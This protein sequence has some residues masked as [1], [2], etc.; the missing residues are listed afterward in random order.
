MTLEKQQ[1]FY[2]FSSVSV[3]HLD[4]TIK[5]FFIVIA[6]FWSMWIIIGAIKRM[7]K[8]DADFSE[9]MP[10]FVRL[11]IVLTIFSLLISNK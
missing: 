3:E 7:Q 5:L 11:A 4:A 9:I 6:M 2:N 1:A 10:Q 8:T